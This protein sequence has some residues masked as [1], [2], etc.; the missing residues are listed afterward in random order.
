MKTSAALVLLSAVSASAF[1]PVHRP[2][3]QTTMALSA[4]AKAAKSKEEDL[5]LTR[6]VIA[7]FLGD[8]LGAAEEAPAKNEEPEKKEE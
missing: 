8:D 7:D 2:A 1:V 6:K 4:K 3:A 5:D